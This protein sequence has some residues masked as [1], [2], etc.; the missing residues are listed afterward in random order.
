MN[1]ALW[2]VQ[3]VLAVAFFA[4]GLMKATRSKAQLEPQMAWVEDVPDNVIKIVGVLEVL[5]AI[6][7]I[8]PALIGIAP[9]LTP[10]AGA[11]LVL[12]MACAAALHARR[13]EPQNIVVN[14]VLL[15]LA[16]FVAWGRFGPYP[17]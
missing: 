14:V 10:L 17:V 9:V 7:L 8:V 16:A 12:L 15:A 5:A 1:I 6:G 4:A 11:G 3:I 2:V 13:S